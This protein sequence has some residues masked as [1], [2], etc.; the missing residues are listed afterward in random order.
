[1][2]FPERFRNLVGGYSVCWIKDQN[3]I[4]Q[5]EETSESFYQETNLMP[6]WSIQVEMLQKSEKNFIKKIKASPNIVK[7]TPK[8]LHRLRRTEN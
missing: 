8:I 1:M 6:Y 4:K 3:S 7:A 2:C 5:S